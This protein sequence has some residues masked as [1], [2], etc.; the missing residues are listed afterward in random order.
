LGGG[1]V[2]VNDAGEDAPA[3]ADRDALVLGPRT[4]VRA[5]LAACHGPPGPAARSPPGLTGVVDERRELLTEPG[6]VAGTQ[7]NLICR[8]INLESH[9]LVRRAPIKIIF[10]L[11]GYLGLT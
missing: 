5:A 6:G 9:R 10:E 1:L 8:A 4:D 3:L 11:D 2:L 7:V